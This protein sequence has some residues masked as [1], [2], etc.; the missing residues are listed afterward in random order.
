MSALATRQD[1]SS[2]GPGELT[3]ARPAGDAGRART[4]VVAAIGVAVG[5][6]AVIIYSCSDSQGQNQALNVNRREVAYVQPTWNLCFGRQV[7]NVD[8]DLALTWGF[9]QRIWGTGKHI[10]FHK[11]D[12]RHAKGS[13]A[14]EYCAAVSEVINSTASDEN[15]DG[16]PDGV[17]PADRVEITVDPATLVMNRP[18]IN[19]VQPEDSTLTI[20]AGHI[21][22][23]DGQPV[24]PPEPIFHEDG[25][26]TVFGY[27]VTGGDSNLT[28]AVEALGLNFFDVGETQ[29]AEAT[30]AITVMGRA[31]SCIRAVTDRVPFEQMFTT[32]AT[33]HVMDESYSKEQVSVTGAAGPWPAP[34]QLRDDQGKTYDDAKNELTQHLADGVDGD[35]G[36]EVRINGT[37]SCAAN[38]TADTS[39]TILAE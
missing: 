21:V 30:R 29:P 23:R 1:A 20:N 7:V 24:E 6:F 31:P 5:L 14:W 8:L 28:A 16:R 26:V 11:T 32:A 34:E 3:R 22:Q 2:R 19:S 25:V 27:N 39:D 10:G 33:R 17:D 36:E 13:V 37:M 4:G 9:Q 38:G 35:D 18:A 15:D 12:T